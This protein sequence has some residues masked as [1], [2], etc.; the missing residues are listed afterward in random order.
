LG[1]K[2][3]AR[4]GIYGSNCPEWFMAMEACNGHSI[5]CVP[6]YD[7]LGITHLFLTWGW[8]QWSLLLIMQRLPLHLYKSQS[9]P[10]YARTRSYTEF[11]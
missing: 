3:T 11:A 9:F 6:L 10:W 2:P 1:V 8:R 7:T 4:C 5:A